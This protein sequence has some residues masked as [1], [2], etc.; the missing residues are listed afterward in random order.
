GGSS[1]GLEAGVAR[2]R[3]LAARDGLLAGAGGFARDLAAAEIGLEAIKITE[4][5]VSAALSSG[6]NP[7]PAASMLKVQRTEMMQRI[8]TLGIEAG[9]AYAGVDQLEARQPGSNIAPVGPSDRLTLMPRYLNN[10]AGSIYG[11][12]NEV[13]RNIMAKLVLGL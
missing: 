3:A 2:I 6:A 7:G 11:G 12:S 9:G 1:A 5:R 4:Q 10:R 8:D 13:Q